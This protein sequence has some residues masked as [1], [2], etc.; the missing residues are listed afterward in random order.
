MDDIPAH[1]L[2]AHSRTITDFYTLAFLNKDYLH[3]S[4]SYERSFLSSVL[5]RDY[6]GM[7]EAAAV[8]RVDL[9]DTMLR[10]EAG[11]IGF[12]KVMTRINKAM[13]RK[14]GGRYN[15][16]L[17]FDFLKRMEPKEEVV[18]ATCL[19]LQCMLLYVHTTIKSGE[20]MVD[21]PMEERM[22][23]W[24]LMYLDKIY[25][26]R[27]LG[28][29]ARPFRNQMAKMVERMKTDKIVAHDLY[30]YEAYETL[31]YICSTIWGGRR[32]CQDVMMLSLHRRIHRGVYNPKATFSFF[33]EGAHSI[34][35]HYS[36]EPDYW[37][38]YDWYWSWHQL[39]YG[40]EA[41]KAGALNPTMFKYVRYRLDCMMGIGE[42]EEVKDEELKTKMNS[43]LEE[44]NHD[45]RATPLST[46]K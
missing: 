3:T 14:R 6:A 5:Q 13:Y 42:Q 2:L 18:Q 44:V 36:M 17:Q 21:T 27:T 35:K 22:R 34:M 4:R 40:Q 23:E 43:F 29:G 9:V 37:T 7:Q 41:F 28:T 1:V 33:A 32:R 8:L 10:W 15:V 46:V 12:E 19:M 39:K 30:L 11:P 26:K 38:E 45:L 20:L 31:G 16:Y 25:R 24:L